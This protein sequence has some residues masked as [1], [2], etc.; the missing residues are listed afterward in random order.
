MNSW[1][2]KSDYQK[3]MEANILSTGANVS[4]KLISCAN[5]AQRVCP[6]VKR[7]S[8]ERGPEHQRTQA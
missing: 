5:A 8:L 6:E 7:L 2:Y 3:L 4:Q 1:V